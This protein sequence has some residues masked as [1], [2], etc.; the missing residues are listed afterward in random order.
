M[1]SALPN[2]DLVHL[3]DRLVEKI[4]VELQSAIDDGRLLTRNGVRRQFKCEGLRYDE[5]GAHCIQGRIEYVEVKDWAP[6]DFFKLRDKIKVTSEYS[7]VA[8]FLN[9]NFS[10]L[11]LAGS[12]DGFVE[13]LMRST[14]PGEEP[15]DSSFVSDFIQ[16]ISERKVRTEAL[17][18]IDGIVVRSDAIQIQWRDTEILLRPT[19]QADIEQEI[20]MGTSEWD[21]TA[22]PSAILEIRTNGGWWEAQ[23]GL[24][25]SLAILRLFGVGSVCYK[26]AK[27]RGRQ[28]AGVYPGTIRPSKHFSKFKYSVGQESSGK[29]IKFWQHLVTFLAPPLVHETS[30]TKDYLA[31]AYE[32]YSEALTSNMG[33]ER[34]VADS[35]MA[36]ESLFLSDSSE[37]QFRLKMSVAK[38][39]GLL[40]HDPIKVAALVKLAYRIRS[41]FVHGGF[42]NPK[43][44]KKI[45]R[46][47]E[48]EQE[49]VRLLLD[50][51]RICIIIFATIHSKPR[52]EILDLI[53]HSMTSSSATQDLETLLENA[54]S[55]LK[56][57]AT[58]VQ[59]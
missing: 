13:Q 27:F 46:L 22:P 35:V 37:L 45:E 30:K 38:V 39:L 12:L 25:Q 34:T 58:V 10:A 47:Y 44:Q 48:S 8:E 51:A 15:V 28:F 9:H 41:T 53:E 59:K 5:D 3:V 36:L 43:E 55:I 7:S 23:N 42:L 1:A 29:L 18:E 14:I 16:W 2:K 21:Y 24:H 19:S 31:T 40:G 56:L 49:F 4:H 11:E 57:D 32:R 33:F 20:T 54:A 50:Y 17:V 26:R 6:R 52:N